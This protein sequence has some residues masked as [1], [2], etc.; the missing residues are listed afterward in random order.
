MVL[1]LLYMTLLCYWTYEAL[2]VSVNEMISNKL[3]GAGKSKLK[4]VS[5]HS[6]LVSQNELC[7]EC[8]T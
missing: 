7:K 8:I 5:K 3:A 4:L 1:G 6:I 2:P